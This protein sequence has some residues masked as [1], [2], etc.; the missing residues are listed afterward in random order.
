MRGL[1]HDAKRGEYGWPWNR[2]HHLAFFEKAGDLETFRVAVALSRDTARR[3]RSGSNLR[4]YDGIDATGYPSHPRSDDASSSRT[5]RDSHHSPSLPCAPHF[6][7]KLQ[8][9][10]A[11]T[12]PAYRNSIGILRSGFQ[13]PFVTDCAGTI[14]SFS[15]QP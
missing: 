15:T 12:K 3:G 7:F 14:A 8:R 13:S 1:T 4:Q 10:T 2:Y 11:F 6:A 5:I 9:V